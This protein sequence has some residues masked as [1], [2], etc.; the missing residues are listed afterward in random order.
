[1]LWTEIQRKIVFPDTV[2]AAEFLFSGVDGN[3]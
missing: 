1:M 2:G 3:H